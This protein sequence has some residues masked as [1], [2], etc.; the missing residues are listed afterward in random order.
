MIEYYG[1]ISYTLTNYLKRDKKHYV[2]KKDRRK[3]LG[4]KAG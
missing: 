4:C 2:Y 3:T 1:V